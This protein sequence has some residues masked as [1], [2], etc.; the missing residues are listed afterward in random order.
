MVDYQEIEDRQIIGLIASLDKDALEE[1]Y[2]RYSTSVYSLAMYML[3]NEAL[4]QEIFLN[5]WLK[6]SSFNA[7]RGQP[8]SWIMSVA[9]P[10]VVNVIRSRRRSSVMTDPAD[11]ETLDLL[12]SG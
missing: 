11:Y 5:I 10:K 2:T 8:R 6:A 4:A 12:P 1:L 7:D 9:H 3:R